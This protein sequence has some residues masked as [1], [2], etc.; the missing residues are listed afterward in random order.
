MYKNLGIIMVI[1]L[2]LAGCSNIDPVSIEGKIFEVNKEKKTF[3]VL[4]ENNLTEQQKADDK[5]DEEAIEAFSVNVDKG[6]EVKGEVNSFNDLEQGQKVAVEI[7]EEY[8]SELVTKDT[9]FNKHSNLPVYEP[10]SIT[11]TPYSKQDVVQELTVEEGYG[12]YT[13]NPEDNEEG[14]YDA[15]PSS[16]AANFPFHEIQVISS[17]SDVKNTEELLGL[18]EDSPTYII[19]DEKEVVFKSDNKKELNEFIKTLEKP[20]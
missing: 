18:F 12:L 2:L 8:D 9:L 19:A 3:V 5:K 14:K 4:V 15:T 7:E 17:V 16:V 1:S 13:F 10:S 6:M 20:N 11:V